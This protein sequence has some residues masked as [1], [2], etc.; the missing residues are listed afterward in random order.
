MFIV[1]V[2]IILSSDLT[3]LHFFSSA[4]LSTGIGD[5][6]M[7]STECQHT[8]TGSDAT[9]KLAAVPIKQ[10]VLTCMNCFSIADEL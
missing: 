4:S 1:T 3:F 9:F 10:H 8:S 2:V 5:K 6:V 7:M